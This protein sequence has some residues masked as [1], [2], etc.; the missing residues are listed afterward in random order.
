MPPKPL[1][2]KRDEKAILK[3]QD[4]APSQGDALARLAIAKEQ[5]RLQVKS[6]MS[7]SQKDEPQK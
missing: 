3:K 2:K 4:A 5:A 1:A 7:Q 6:Q